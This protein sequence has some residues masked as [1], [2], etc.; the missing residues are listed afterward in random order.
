MNTSQ[1]KSYAP[2]ARRD[3][4]QVVTAR[5]NMLGLSESKIIPAEIKGEIAIIEGRAYPKSIATSRE[6]IIER[7]NSEGF[8][9]VIEKTAYTWFNRIVAL[10]YMEL[11]DYLDHGY[12]ALSNRSDSDIPEILEKATEIELPGLNKD[13]VIE[14][15]LAGNK[16]NELYRMLLVAQCNALH[17]AMPFLFEHI[18][19]ETELLLPDNLLHSD[20]IIRKLVND[21]D[22]EAWNEVEIIGWLYQFYI[23]EK[24]DEVIGKVVKSEDIPA[25]TQLFTPNWIVKYMV[26]NTLGRMW[27]ATYPESTLQEKM[28]YYIEP[29]EQEPE[30]QKQL[31]EITPKELNPEGLTFLDPACGS[32][33]ILVE[34]YELL[35]E[36]YLER[37][38]R[39]RDI[40]ELI[41]KKNLYGI[42]IDDRAAQLAGF[43]LL[44]KAREDDSRIFAKDD[45]ELNV[46]SMK[47]SDDSDEDNVLTTQLQKEGND[48]SNILQ[49]IK[50][51]KSS[52]IFGSLITVPNK[53]AGNLGEIKALINKVVD[54]YHVCKSYGEIILN[55]IQQAKILSNKYDCVVTNPPYMGSKAMNGVLKKFAAEN[56]SDSKSDLF[57]MF[58]EK[59]SA[60]SKSNQY[61]GLITMQSW[62]FLSSYE[63]LREDILTN[64]T[65]TTMAH[66]GPRA[67]SSISGEVVQTT[68]FVIKNNFFDNYIPT[69]FRLIKGGEQAKK[70][71]FLKRENK[72]NQIKQNDFKK[73]PGSPIAYWVSD[74]VRQVFDRSN[75]MGELCTAVAG[76]QTGD[77][78]KFL[79]L[80]FEVSIVNIKF[81]CKNTREALESK[82]KWFPYN[83]GGAFRKWYGNNEYVVNWENDGCEIKNFYDKN[84]KLRSRPQ[85]TKYYFRESITWTAT[86]SSYFGVRY[87][88]NG[89]IFDVKGSSGFT[90]S[91]FKNIVLGLLITKQTQYF[92][93]FLNPTI[94]TQTGNIGSLPVSDKIIQDDNQKK[95]INCCVN[96]CVEIERHDWDSF[97]TSWDFK[98][99]PILS[100][101]LKSKNIKES[102]FNWQKQCN[103]NI[104]KM[105]ELEEEN[106]RIFIDAYGLQDE[107]TP[108]VPEDQVTLARS[109]QEEDIK[110]LISYS[111]GCMMGRYSLDEPGLIYANSGNEDFDRSKYKSFPADDDGIVPVSDIKWFHDDATNRF[112]EFIKVAWNEDTLDE[113]LDFVAESVGQ[114][115]G[116][117][118]TDAIRRY[119]S[120]SFFKDHLKTY[121]KRPIY[122]LFSSGKQKAFAC[123]VYLHRYNESTLARMRSAYVTPLHGKLNARMEHL[124]NEIEAEPTT[125]AKKKLEK[126]LEMFKKKHE[127]LVKFDDE[128]RHYAD[129]C[130]KLDLDDGVKVNYGKF[131]NLLAEKT[132]VVG[133]KKE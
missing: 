13:K 67:F 59:C 32:G 26:Q 120:S 95:R 107:L 83:K 31:E 51:F 47:N 60:F 21:I 86:S 118:S 124:R 7:I 84:G 127:E 3:F 9:N 34:A 72:F 64:L 39:T 62:M 76:L 75:P 77:N 82:L 16:D 98:N 1:I 69:F 63:R 12:R 131:G 28:E 53:L 121:K 106:N 54:E 133:K 97:E 20:S 61:F 48:I 78:D 114:K 129:M 4:I 19:D 116:E 132:A 99:S 30:V 122:W 38:Y 41:L 25:A 40:P 79:R 6:K 15:R 101:E 119:I 123:L 71:S 50:L 108:E 17:K 66:L 43:V 27:M 115:S 46:I 110:R 100:N 5:A 49:L 92:L 89:F 80:W 52:K 87:S 113:N 91:E 37:G 104:A 44:M 58:I 65:I 23:S 14:L 130:I 81:D 85:N 111:I 102:Y 70:E 36:I 109:D 18:Y 56:F 2:K 94:E 74:R 128:L 117:L 10:R 55:L 112:I 8:I 29:A 105:K 57:A 90:K 45:I 33:H 73:I 22:D 11:H 35:K 88:N 42:D 96:K 126:Q 93:R 103:D 125:S 24:K 68:T